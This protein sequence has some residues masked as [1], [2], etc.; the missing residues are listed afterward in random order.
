MLDRSLSKQ[1][2]LMCLF[3]ALA[4]TGSNA[5]EVTTATSYVR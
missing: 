3:W 2:L 5:I 1:L 4:M